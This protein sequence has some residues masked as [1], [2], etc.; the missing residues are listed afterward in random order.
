MSGTN[1]TTEYA[2]LVS[3]WRR[4]RPSPSVRD[5]AGPVRQIQYGG[6]E[7]SMSGVKRPAFH[8]L[9]PNA[10]TKLFYFTCILHVM[11]LV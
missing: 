3:R 5:V 2:L 6:P 10:G 7:V 1:I 11:C 9:R 8:F 4:L